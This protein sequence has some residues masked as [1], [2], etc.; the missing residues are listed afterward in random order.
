[1]GFAVKPDLLSGLVWLG[2]GLY[3]IWEGLDLGLGSASDPGSGALI[4]W[5][6]V[7]LAGLAAGLI[8]DAFR[9]PT[10]EGLAA[11]WA[12]TRWPKVVWITLVLAAYGMALLPVGFLIST[13]VFLFILFVSVEW[14]R[15]PVAGA[16]A[17]LSTLGVYLLFARVLG[18]S[19]PRGL[20]AF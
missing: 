6:G 4:F 14:T 9:Q 15:P 1:V 8:V 5:A 18:V 11:L 12:G 20:L 10:G 13:V 19:L 16:M 17:V 2:V 7:L 3:A